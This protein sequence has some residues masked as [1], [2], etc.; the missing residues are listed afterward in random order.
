M[1]STE[2]Q[3]DSKKDAPLLPMEEMRT[4]SFPNACCIRFRTYE[5][6]SKISG[7]ERGVR[8]SM[9]VQCSH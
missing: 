5:L 9:S 7:S 4:V 8:V 1:V 2:E 6:R 3:T